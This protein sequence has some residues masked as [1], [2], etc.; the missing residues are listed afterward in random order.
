M[1]AGFKALGR[2]V[3]GSRGDLGSE[4]DALLDEVIAHTYLLYS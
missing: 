3:S 2:T 1:S 4:A